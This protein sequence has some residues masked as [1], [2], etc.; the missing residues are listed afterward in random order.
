LPES[1]HRLITNYIVDGDI[2]QRIYE[3]RGNPISG[4]IQPISAGREDIKARLR[5]RYGPLAGPLLVVRELQNSLRVH[6][7]DRALDLI[8]AQTG[9]ERI[10]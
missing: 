8:A 4:E 2:A 3:W 10:K 9:A 5:A 6:S 7:L 1:A